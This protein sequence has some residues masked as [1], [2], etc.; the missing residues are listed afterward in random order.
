[1]NQEKIS[2]QDHVSPNNSKI[3]NKDND[4]EELDDENENFE[5]QHTSTQT[6]A[7][8]INSIPQNSSNSHTQRP[9]RFFLHSLPQHFPSSDDRD[10]SEH[11]QN[12]LDS[13]PPQ[14]PIRVFL[15]SLSQNV[16]FSDDGDSSE[17]SQNGL[18]NDITE[19]NDNS[20]TDPTPPSYQVPESDI[21]VASADGAA[22]SLSRFS[23]RYIHSNN[24]FSIPQA[25]SIVPSWTEKPIFIQYPS[26]TYG[27]FFNYSFIFI[28]ICI[29][30]ISVP[31]QVIQRKAINNVTN[32]PTQMLSIAPSLSP[33][34]SE[35]HNDTQ[36]NI[37]MNEEKADVNDLMGY[38]V[39][40]SSDGNTVAVG[41]HKTFHLYSYLEESNIGGGW[42]KVFDLA[43]TVSAKN[44]K[45]DLSYG[46]VVSISSDGHYVVVGDLFASYEFIETGA[47]M[48]FSNVDGS[49]SDGNGY[50]EIVQWHQVGPTIYGEKE[51]V[52]F[53]STVNIA[54][55]G[56]RIAFNTNNGNGFAAVYD[57]DGSEWIEKMKIEHI[58]GYNGDLALS[59]NGKFLAMPQSQPDFVHIFELTTFTKFQTLIGFGA[60]DF[61]HFMSFSHDGHVLAIS[62]WKVGIVEL[63]RIHPNT[64]R[65]VPFSVPISVANVTG[66]GY[67]VSVSG[68]GNYVVAGAVSHPSM[69]QMESGEFDDTEYWIDYISD[70]GSVFVFKIG[71]NDWEEVDK[72]KYD[73]ALYD[74]IGWSVSISRSG[75]V[76]AF[77]G[78]GTGGKHGDGPNKRG[79]V[80]ICSGDRML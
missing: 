19:T 17:H 1:M 3:N 79:Q 57:F 43:E 74:K 67:S 63:F 60:Y 46:T 70:D 52:R 38:S 24:D 51:Y 23:I 66:L 50:G 8:P 11:G 5:K 42:V 10:S 80:G 27:R 77:G 56:E 59:P 22:P 2:K 58:V 68:N 16:S 47:V 71:D 29:V 64:Q 32:Q 65:Y 48:V 6:A 76:V 37:N 36:I 72:F 4:E 78:Y 31:V 41:G 53:G 26:F 39:S 18:E 69:K 61:G 73:K 55:G 49:G 9:T 35:W 62:S 45:E 7:L 30:V 15:H 21:Y 25:T 12:S 14:R 20:I 28:I 54:D 40:L 44:I 75:D 33:L 13:T 34:I